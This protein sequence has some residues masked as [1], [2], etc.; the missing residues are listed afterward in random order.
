MCNLIHLMSAHGRRQYEERRKDMNALKNDKNPH[1]HL[2]EWPANS[3]F[4]PV[5]KRLKKIL[6]IKKEKYND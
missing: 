1:Y 5:Q 2:P 6:Q 4:N 3:Y